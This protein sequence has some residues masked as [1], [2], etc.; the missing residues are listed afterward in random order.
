MGLEGHQIPLLSRIMNLAQ[1][2][3]VFY[4]SSGPSSAID[5]A[6]KRSGRWFEPSLVKVFCSLA[7]NM[8]LWDDVENANRR[9]IDFEPADHVRARLEN[10]CL[11]FAD[12]IDAKSP[13][14]YRHSTGVAAAAV[15][16]ATTLDLSEADVTLIRRSAL[17]HDIGKLSV[18]NTILDKPDKLTTPEWQIV[19]EHPRYS[20][21]ILQRIPGFG[22]I[23]EIAGS[24]HE[25]L[26]GSG[27]FRNMS[28]AQLSLPARIVAVADMYDALTAARPYREALP[29]DTVFATLQKESL[30]STCLEALKCASGFGRA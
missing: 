20:L 7:N 6:L 4:T 17:L 1:T 25:K 26:D 22:R 19:R 27:Y 16:I 21:E 14:T 15:S 8:S 18:P 2:A 10:I 13:F 9:V 11:A 28:G 30:D 23:S 5:V 12:V 3:E 24:H 29:A